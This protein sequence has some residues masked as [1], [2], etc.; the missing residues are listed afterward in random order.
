MGGGASKSNTQATEGSPAKG[1]KSS[2]IS[3]RQLPVHTSEEVNLTK[4]NPNA[5][6]RLAFATGWTDQTRMN[7]NY[8]ETIQG[9][10]EAT[11]NINYEVSAAMG[12]TAKIRDAAEAFHDKWPLRVKGYNCRL[13]SKLELIGT[14]A[15]HG[16][17]LVNVLEGL[18]GLKQLLDAQGRVAS[19]PQ[20]FECPQNC[21]CPIATA[22]S[23][24]GEGRQEV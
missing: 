22:P 18:D 6:T 14:G 21:L 10:I 13:E 17:L 7:M 24:P 11:N 5:P 20:G 15:E 9:R 23:Q 4:P 19:L 16:D 8:Q 1:T 2:F 12:K 3:T